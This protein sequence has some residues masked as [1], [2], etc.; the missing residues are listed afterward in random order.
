[1]QNPV[2][3]H[4]AVDKNISAVNS[5]RKASDENRSA[6]QKVIDTVSEFFGSKTSLYLHLF[7]YGA[8]IWFRLLGSSSLIKELGATTENLSSIASLEAIFLTVFVLV[9]QSRMKSLERKNMDLHLQMSM[10]AEHEVT[11]LA[12]MTDL[13]AKHLGVDT[14]HIKDLAAVKRD[15]SPTEILQRLSAQEEETPTTMGHGKKT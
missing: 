14:S 2:S 7:F 9:N 5:H 3:T 11:R 1:M 4:T 12:Q 13:I 6:D 10:L 8:F 15:V